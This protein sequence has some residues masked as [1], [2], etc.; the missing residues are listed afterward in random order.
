[1]APISSPITSSYIHTLPWSPTDLSIVPHC[2]MF[3]LPSYYC[4]SLTTHHTPTNFYH[5]PRLSSSEISP[6]T[7]LAPKKVGSLSSIHSLNFR[8]TLCVPS[9]AHCIKMTDFLTCSPTRLNLWGWSSVISNPSAYYHARPWENAQQVSIKWIK[10][11]LVA[12]VFWSLCRWG[13]GGCLDFVLQ[14]C[15]LT[16]K[17][18]IWIAQV[19]PLF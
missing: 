10:P 4:S 7:G 12:L 15:F 9:P 2:I 8:N 13:W 17:K 16:E 5:L 6:S 1:M 18:P 19:Q 14:H 11:Q 3:F